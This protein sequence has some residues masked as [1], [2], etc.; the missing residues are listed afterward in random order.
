MKKTDKY[1][2]K[3]YVIGIRNQQLAFMDGVAKS[4]AKSFHVSDEQ[5]HE[6]LVRTDDEYKRAKIIADYIDHLLTLD[7]G[8][9]AVLADH[10]KRINRC[11]EVEEA[12]LEMARGK[13]PLPTQEECRAMANQIG[14]PKL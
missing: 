10:A 9:D 6:S 13:R 4:F 2:A 5:A 7:N 1:A 14:A 8:V 11:A 3:S 12:L